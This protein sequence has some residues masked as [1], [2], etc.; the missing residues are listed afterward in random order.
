M[1]GPCSFKN[2]T[3]SASLETLLKPVLIGYWIK[4]WAAT[5]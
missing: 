1:A 3:N 2:T 4:D 5:V